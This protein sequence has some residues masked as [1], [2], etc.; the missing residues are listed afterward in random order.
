[1]VV[2][3]SW[4]LTLLMRG[5]TGW[6]DVSVIWCADDPG[7]WEYGGDLTYDFAAAT[8]AWGLKLSVHKQPTVASDCL[9]LL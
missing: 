5:W 9:G 8:V 2:A 4:W 6:T 3:F 7:M 1:M